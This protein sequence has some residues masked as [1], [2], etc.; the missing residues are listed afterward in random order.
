MCEYLHVALYVCVCIGMYSVYTDVYVCVYLY[1]HICACVQ[2]A[3]CEYLHT[4][5]RY[6]QQI[7]I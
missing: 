6:L 4:H 2:I 7:S 5:D 3:M 1:L